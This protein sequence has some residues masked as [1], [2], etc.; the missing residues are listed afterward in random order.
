M[1]A[2]CLNYFRHKKIACLKNAQFK[3]SKVW[4]SIEYSTKFVVYLKFK[5]TKFLGKITPGATDNYGLETF[6]SLFISRG[7]NEDWLARPRL[8]WVWAHC[9]ECDVH[10]ETERPVDWAEDCQCSEL[11]PGVPPPPASPGLGPGPGSGDW[12]WPRPGS[13]SS[14]SGE[15]RGSETSGIWWQLTCDTGVLTSLTSVPSPHLAHY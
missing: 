13:L 12:R 7:H 6:F 1:I 4:N 10:L 11:G 8:I 3:E 2:I 5:F 14:E 9:S 15:R